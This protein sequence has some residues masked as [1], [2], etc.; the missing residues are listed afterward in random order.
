MGIRTGIVS[1]IKEVL[2]TAAISLL[3]FWFVY[4]FLV[5]P[6]RVKGD[7]M[8]PNFHDGELLLTEKIT[9]RFGSYHRGDVIVFRAPSA[10]N[11]DYIKRIIGLPGETVR[12]KD[13]SIYINSEKLN[14]PYE[15][16]KTQG[17]VEITLPENE[18]LVLGDNRASS[19]DSRS[20]GPINQNAIRGRTWLVYWPITKTSNSKGARFISR[21]NYSIPDSLN[22]H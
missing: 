20:F 22:Q 5:Q 12:L 16:Q 18:Y 11:L 1:I 9:G 21:V 8:L 17:N 2:Q 6:H 13:G 19:S 7:S 15:I 10:E 14:E 3:I 4:T